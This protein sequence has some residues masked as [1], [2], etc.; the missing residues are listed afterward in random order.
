[1]KIKSFSLPAR[2]RLELKLVKKRRI[3]DERPLLLRLGDLRRVRK[4]SRTSRFLRH[5]F[6]HKR[7]RQAFGANLA[8]IAIAGSIAPTIQP[9]IKAENV[10]MTNSVDANVVTI[11]NVQYP[12]VNTKINQG[13]AFYH[14]GIDLDGDVGDE[15]RTFKNGTVTEVG[16]STFGYGNAIL[17]DHTEGVVSLYAHLSKILVSKG[18]AV[19]TSTVIGQV[20][21][22]GR[23][24]GA[25]LHF[26]VRINGRTVNPFTYLP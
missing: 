12:T 18:Q 24:T 6:E 19:D 22:S 20:G 10:E 17:I 15:V 25:H 13:Y 21:S 1:M 8:I 11:K 4:G 5:I 7:V 14:P 26:E 2:Y 23:S 16:Y 9:G 3:S